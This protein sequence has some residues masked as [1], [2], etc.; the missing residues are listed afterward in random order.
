MVERGVV[1]VVS[2]VVV[3]VVVTVLSLVSHFTT[4][5]LRKLFNPFKSL[6]TSRSSG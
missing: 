3:V 2:V 1:V 4:V 5:E 6:L